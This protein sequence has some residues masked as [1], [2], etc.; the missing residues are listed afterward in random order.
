[1]QSD[2]QRHMEG[3]SLQTTPQLEKT[4]QFPVQ[5]KKQLDHESSPSRTPSARVNPVKTN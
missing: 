2:W 4:G 1:M 3:F 5:M